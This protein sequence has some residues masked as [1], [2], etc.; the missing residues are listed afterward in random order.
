M[1]LTERRLV[2]MQHVQEKIDAA[3]DSPPLPTTTKGMVGVTKSGEALPR[4]L[5]S[6]S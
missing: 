5:I 1:R 3:D 4:G 2:N 6:I